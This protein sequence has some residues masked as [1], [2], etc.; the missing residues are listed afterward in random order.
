MLKWTE[1]LYR[2]LMRTKS[3]GGD[4]GG[5]RQVE[6][7]KGNRRLLVFPEA[8]LM[9]E[10]A[11]RL[12]K[13]EKEHNENQGYQL[14]RLWADGNGGRNEEILLVDLGRGLS[15]DDELSRGGEECFAG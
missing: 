1:I 11:L 6:R 9:M 7:R 12:Q 15:G 4:S 14:A 8:R 13:H 10:A 3:D 2:I 5:G